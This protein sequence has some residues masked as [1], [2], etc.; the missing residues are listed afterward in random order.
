MHPSP[1]KAVRALL[2][3]S[4]ATLTPAAAA[5][6]GYCFINN[7]A[8][9]AQ[10]LCEHGKRVAIIDVDYHHGNGTQDIFYA[11]SDVLYARNRFP[12]RVFVTL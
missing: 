12:H 4:P 7:A 5:Q 11:R 8:I 9:A 6:G 3:H 10:I 1:C 2:A